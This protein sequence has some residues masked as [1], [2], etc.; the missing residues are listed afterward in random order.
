MVVGIEFW[1]LRLGCYGAFVW[2][3]LFVWLGFEFSFSWFAFDVR[4]FV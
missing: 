3:D 1:C 4:R 2:L